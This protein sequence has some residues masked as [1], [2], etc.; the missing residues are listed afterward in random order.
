MSNKHDLSLV[1]QDTIEIKFSDD[2]IFTIPKD[3]N[4]EFTYKLVDFEEKA[5]NAESNKEQ[6]DLFVDMVVLILGQDKKHDV[7]EQFIKQLHFSQIQAVVQ[8][9][10]EQVAENQNNPN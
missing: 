2:A 7:T 9:Y 8:I 1:N 4:M 5:K 3:P 10:Q 6:F